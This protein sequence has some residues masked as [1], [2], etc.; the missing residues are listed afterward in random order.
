[1]QYVIENP[2]R[3]Y[4]I[5]FIRRMHR[6]YGARAVC[7]YTTPNA[8]PVSR[9][10]HPELFSQ[11]YVAAHYRAT[12][13]GLPR[14]IEHLR[15]HH[16][17]RAIIPHNEMSVSNA[18]TIAEGLGLDWVQP[19]IMRRFRD[20]FAL[21]TH[22]RAADPGLRIN[23]AELARSPAEALDIVR[24]NG[25]SRFVL[26]PN[27]GAANKNVGIFSADDP[28]SLV[29]S[30]WKRTQ[31]RTVLLE[32]FIG[33][34]EYHCNGQVD[35]EGNVTI[36]DIGRTH[37]TESARREIV[38]L[39]VSQASRSDPN[40]AAIADYTRRMIVA[41]GLRRS[42]FH[43]ELRVD[44]SGPCLL[45]CGARLVGAEWA[46]FIHVMHGP[47][48]DVFDLAA[49]YYV[50]AE[51]YGPPGL[52]WE[53]YDS[54]TLIKLRGVS[55]RAETIERLEGVKEAERLRQFLGWNQKPALGQTLAATNSLTTSPYSMMLRCR[56]L[57]EAD[58]VERKI[59]RLIKWNK[60]ARPFSPMQKFAH[61]FGHR[62]AH[63]R[64]KFAR[65]RD[66]GANLVSAVFE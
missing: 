47:R 57:A 61:A 27:N 12:P 63:L 28:A 66:A 46:R 5:D 45:E 54:S 3:S 4:G 10:E 33:G 24:R 25:L 56:T 1:M 51:S 22:L 21:K 7:Y 16:S 39:R 44:E 42:P 9:R 53:H 2:T 20:K 18:V 64:A 65:D 62:L 8:L 38:C 15:A 31:A 55:K 14:F 17:I 6:R 49:H 32:E 23:H 36:I 19:A 11:E 58:K 13:K 41:S 43:A 29:K 30:Y 26:K 34:L 48:F 60:Q 40:F 59:R 35:A 50:S 52:D 37:C